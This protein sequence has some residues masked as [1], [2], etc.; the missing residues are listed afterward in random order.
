L[1]TQPERAST[2][3]RP[4]QA[5][6]FFSWVIFAATAGSPQQATRLDRS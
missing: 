4:V 1:A 6:V 5:G 2:A 3:T